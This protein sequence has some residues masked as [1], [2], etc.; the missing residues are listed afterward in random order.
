MTA[1]EALIAAF[2][3]GME[4]NDWTDADEEEAERLLPSLIEAGYA[5]VTS[6][7]EFYDT[8]A[9]TPAGVARYDVLIAEG[10]AA[11]APD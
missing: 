6:T 11:P 10:R 1:D 9:F 5:E 4:S 3:L 8:W 2:E 7:G